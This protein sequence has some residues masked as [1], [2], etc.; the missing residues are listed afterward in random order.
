[1]PS[2]SS[3]DQIDVSRVTTRK[4]ITNADGDGDLKVEDSA[5]SWV[6]LAGAAM[7][8][9]LV[10]GMYKSFGLVLAALEQQHGFTSAQVA[11]IPALFF[12][13]SFLFA[14]LCGVLCRR[15]SERTGWHHLDDAGTRL[16]WSHE[17]HLHVIRHER[18]YLRR[19]TGI[20]AH[21]RDANGD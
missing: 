11:V 14:P 4:Q 13:V 19:R 7:K 1:M 10:G 20:R 3:V 18:T 16:Q 8:F 9:V 6:V 21:S 12:A 2:P 5:F 17:Q 15:F